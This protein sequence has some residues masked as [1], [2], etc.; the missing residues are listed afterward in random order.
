MATPF[1]E[2]YISLSRLDQCTLLG[3][4]L[5]PQDVKMGETSNLLS[6]FMLIWGLTSYFIAYNKMIISFLEAKFINIWREFH[7]N[8]VVMSVGLEL[9]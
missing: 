7:K 9:E 2:A 6:K 8:S 1:L 4:L 5:Q 3:V